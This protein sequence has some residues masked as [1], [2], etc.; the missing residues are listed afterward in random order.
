MSSHTGQARRAAAL[1]PA[2]AAAVGFLVRSAAMLAVQALALIV[3]T[4]L[5]SGSTLSVQAALLVAV[6]MALINAL[7][8]PLLTRIALPLTIITFGLGSL[9]LSAGDGRARVLRGRRQDARRSAKTSR[10]RSGWRSS[11]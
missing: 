5:L 10:S 6:V 7:L 9:V 3:L 1:A 4:A 2:G 11:R 8:W